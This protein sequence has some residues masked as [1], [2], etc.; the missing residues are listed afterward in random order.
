MYFCESRSCSATQTCT[1]SSSTG[2]YYC[3]DDGPEPGTT[4]PPTGTPAPPTGVEGPGGVTIPD[5]GGSGGTGG[6]GG[7]DPPGPTGPTTPTGP[8]D[9]TGPTY[10]DLTCHDFDPGYCKAQ[11]DPHYHSFDGAH[12]DFMGTCQYLLVG[13][14]YSNSTSVASGLAPFNVRVQHR[15]AWAPRTDVAMTEH[16]WFDIHSRDE[17]SLNGLATYTIYMYI[18]DPPQGSGRPTTIATQIFNNALGYSFVASEV[19]NP[20]FHMVNKGKRVTVTTWFGV[21]VRYTAEKWAVEVYVSNCYSGLTMGL[22]GNYDG[23]ASNDY[24]TPDGLLYPDALVVPWAQTWE[25]PNQVPGCTQG[26]T[27][28]EE[29]TDTA[30]IAQCERL[31]SDTDVFSSCHAT[32][33]PTSSY[34]DCLFDYCLES[35]PELLCAMYDQYASSCL[36]AMQQAGTLTSFNDP[37]CD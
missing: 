8:I 4:Q 37:I 30:V 3:E 13:V 5:G 1:Y 27:T 20:D 9:P 11:G 22:C 31:T 14:A 23:S 29:C 33:D 28:F 18:A 25:I 32:L 6:T 21:Q 24:T 7:P 36:Y 35:T 16:V 2:A 12:F 34:D 19:V 17:A 10:P 15:Q 26:P